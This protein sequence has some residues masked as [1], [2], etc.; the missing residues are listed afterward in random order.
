[1]YIGQ[2]VADRYN[3]VLI[4]DWSE[5]D[6]KIIT[7]DKVKKCPKAQ[8]PKVSQDHL[9]TVTTTCTNK[10]GAH[11]LWQEKGACVDHPTY[12]REGRERESSQSLP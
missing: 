10:T 8:I 6:M 3:L 2:K 11:E 4:C 5:V 1:M 7:Y 9:H 12:K